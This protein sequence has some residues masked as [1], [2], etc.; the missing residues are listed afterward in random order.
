MT[1]PIVPGQ[2]PRP[3]TLATVMPA[4]PRPPHRRGI[5]IGSLVVGSVVLVAAITAGALVI[6]H[7]TATPTALTVTGSLTLIVI[8]P[9]AQGHECAGTGGYSD[10]HAGTEVVVYG[11]GDDTLGLGRLGP[12]VVSYARSCVFLFVVPDL[13]AGK[14]FYAI[15]VSHRGRIH[16]TEAQI[17]GP[18]ELTLGHGD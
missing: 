9:F 4:P 5:L 7:R 10:I 1:V 13:P 17:H 6:L 15:E 12:G 18:V 8:E 11:A 2:P 16:F 3:I 14:G